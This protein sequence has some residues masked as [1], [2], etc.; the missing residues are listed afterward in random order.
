EMKKTSLSFKFI[1]SFDAD[2]KVDFEF[3]NDA[4]ELKYLVHVPVTSGSIEKPMSVETIVTIKEPE[5]KIFKETT[6]LVY[7]ISPIVSLN[8]FSPDTNGS[9]SLQSNASFLFEM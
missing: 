7:K 3:L 4:N 2:F 1:N 9:I 5:I 6:K 8:P